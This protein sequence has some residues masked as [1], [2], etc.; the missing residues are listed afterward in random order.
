MQGKGLTL[1]ELLVA[2]AVASLL[3]FAA[4]RATT[5]LWRSQAAAEPLTAQQDNLAGLD[6]LLAAEL[7]H[8]DRYRNVPGGFELQSRAELEEKTLDRRHLPSLVRYEV[9]TVGQSSWL[10]RTQTRDQAGKPT[11][12]LVYP[13]VTAVSL[14]PAGSVEKPL[15]QWQAVPEHAGVTVDVAGQQK[16]EFVYRIR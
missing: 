8:A 10:V 11:V 3:A 15:P 1:V 13:D 9:R 14:H 4:L 12:E 6:R 7:I 5:A 16:R 2:L